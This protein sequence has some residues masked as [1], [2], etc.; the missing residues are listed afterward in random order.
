[1]D[2]LMVC[3]V[4]VINIYHTV[5][6]KWENTSLS[7]GMENK[8]ILNLNMIFNNLDI[9]LVRECI[10]CI[11]VNLAISTQHGAPFEISAC[12]ENE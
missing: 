5:L 8:N 1:M 6:S 2:W 10:S 9:Y 7:L 11:S 3:S 4:D 12:R